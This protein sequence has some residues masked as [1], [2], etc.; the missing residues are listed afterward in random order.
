MRMKRL[1]RTGLLVSE[2]CL[3]TMTFGGRS[4]FWRVMGALQ[5]EA[6]DNLVKASFDAGVNFFDT[7]N[8]YSNGESERA[9]G[10][11]ISG[12]GL[13]RDEIVIATKA[14]GRMQ[15]SAGKDESPAEQAEAARRQK[16]V[17]ISGLSRKHLFDAVD[18]SLMRLGLDHI[19]LYQIHG[20]DP[21]TPLEE[22]LAALDDIVRSGR[23]R[24]L[25]LCNL[26]AWQIAKSL[27][28]SALRGLAR[29]ES[30]QMYYSIAGRELE[31]EIVPLA[32][33]EELA[34][35]PW[36]PLAGGFLSGKFAREG[37]GP[38][39]ARRATFDFPPVNKDKAF[40]I[41]DAMRPM[42]EARG[43]SVARIA[44]AWLL[45]QP[46]V[47]SVIIGARTP[48]QLADNLAAADVKL[49]PDELAKLDGVSALSLEYPGW[50]L[51]RQG[52][53]RLALLQ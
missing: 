29:F 26:A 49:T 44:L 37:A 30:L 4:S 23:V 28:L 20:F 33:S 47:T 7:A 27:G 10:Q 36:S 24:Y 16:G 22:T 43:A 3:G 53:D 19:D 46:A 48:E 2:V 18:A 45:H 8:V 11:A 15:V 42:A 34:I 13:P 50:M 32:Q 17:N 31:R 1:G 21:L 9:L 39:D 40:D 35:L 52:A 12:L 51:A 38:N 25:G 5:Q 14:H 6:C 41:I